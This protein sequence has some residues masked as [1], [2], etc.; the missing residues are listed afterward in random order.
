[1]FLDSAYVLALALVDDYNHAAAT[2]H[3][4]VLAGTSPKLMTTSLVL[5]EVVTLLNKRGF[6]QR[7]VGGKVERLCDVAAAVAHRHDRVTIS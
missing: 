2:E 5:G 3:W 7:A 6:H 1:M 4:K